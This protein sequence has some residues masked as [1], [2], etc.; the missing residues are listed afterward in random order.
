MNILGTN[1]TGAD[2]IGADLTGARCNHR[3]R[4]PDG[5]DPVKH[6]ALLVR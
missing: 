3:T 1:L 6:G 4:W 2:L 5:F